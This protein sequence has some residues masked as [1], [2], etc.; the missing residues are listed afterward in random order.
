MDSR[1]TF[2][3]PP[4]CDVATDLDSGTP[5]WIGGQGIRAVRQANPPGKAR[6]RVRAKARASSEARGSRSR[7]K[8]LA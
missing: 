2:L 4:A 1:L 8:L 5:Y 6:T 7:E 3:P